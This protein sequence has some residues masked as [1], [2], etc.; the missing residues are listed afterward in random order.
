MRI[1]SLLEEAAAPT[2]IDLL[3][4]DVEGAELSVLRGSDHQ[5]Y[6]FRHIVVECRDI[7]PLQKY[8]EDQGYKIVERLTVHDYL[9]VDGS[10][11]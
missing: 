5:K 8:L 10:G 6:R 4:L 9:S 1:T 7:P 3:S 11:T 2:Q